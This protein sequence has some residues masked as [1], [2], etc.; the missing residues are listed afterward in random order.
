MEKQVLKKIIN[1]LNLSRDYKDKFF[2]F[3]YKGVKDNG[4]DSL[5][6]MIEVTYQ[7]LVDLRNTASLIPGQSYRITDYECTT[8]QENTKSAGH[9]FDIIV[10]ADDEKTLNEN[11]RAINHKGD[12]YFKDCN[13]AAWELK[14]SLDND[15]TKFVWAQ[16]GGI[17]SMDSSN[18]NGVPLK[19][20]PAFDNYNYNHPDYKYAWGTDADIEDGDVINFVFSKT[21]YPLPG[22]IVFV[23]WLGG[24]TTI[25]DNGK[26]V[27]YYMKDEWNNECPY[28]FKN[29]MFNGDWGYYAYTFNWI[30]DR[31]D[32]SY[33]DLSVMQ[34]THKNDDGGY[35]HTYGNIIKSHG[36]N[37]DYGINY[38]RPY[39]LNFIVFLNLE[40]YDEG[41]YYGCN[42]NIFGNDCH[43]NIFRDSC[44][45]NIFGNNCHH[46][47]LCSDSSNNTFR[48]NCHHN[49][50]DNY[51]NFNTLESNCIY[52][53]LGNNCHHNIF[54]YD[55]IYN[56]FGNRYHIITLGNEC[57]YNTFGSSTS[58]K[59]DY[60]CYISLGN[61]VTNNKIYGTT[62]STANKQ[63]QNIHIAQYLR[64][65]TIQVE[66]GLN[67]ETYVGLNTDGELVIRNIFDN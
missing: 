60:C 29:I 53:T 46:N 20:C 6:K 24:Y 37:D 33:D 56:T 26:G 41:L 40:S 5:N 35:S 50:F 10:I 67:Y 61:K 63:L 18:S 2:N 21:E 19:R 55:C 58:S 30:N 1:S 54:G 59:I 64:Y 15:N 42:N 3:L 49:T 8:I 43:Y 62:T 32:N 38:G 7:Q 39:S 47:E 36:Y 14:Y 4:G 65:K 13:L 9:Q 44:K 28:D 48:D 22:D 12:E 23:D 45:F 31:S 34:F 17:E 57:S 16:R 66:T 11:A 27:I 25:K 52:N 51:C